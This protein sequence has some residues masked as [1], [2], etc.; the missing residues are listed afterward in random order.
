MGVL[1]GVTFLVQIG[2]RE[3]WIL[4]EITIDT[5]KDLLIVGQKNRLLHYQQLGLA[6]TIALASVLSKDGGEKVQRSVK[7]QLN[8]LD[9]AFI[10]VDN[11]EYED[12]WL[13]D[14]PQRPRRRKKK[15]P[16][17]DVEKMLRRFHA[18]F[19]RIN[20]R[21]PSFNSAVE[22]ANKEQQAAKAMREAKQE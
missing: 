5:F 3:Q 15:N 18:Q 9:E 2:Y 17:K 1:E 4:E 22:R 20:P 21:I 8:S 11:D 7:E 12:D 16:E 10:G 14:Q 19:A 13:D 6:Y